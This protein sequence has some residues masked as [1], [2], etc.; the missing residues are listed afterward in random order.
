MT[1]NPTKPDLKTIQQ[2]TPDVNK[3]FSFKWLIILLAL[4]GACILA[5]YFMNFSGSW[6]NQADFGA[7]GDYVGGVLNPVL[8]FATV[9]LLIWSLKMQRD[10]LSL[11]RQE[12][13]LTRQELAETK[14]ETALS[15]QAMEAQVNHVKV[16]AELNELTRLLDR[17][18][19]KYETLIGMRFPLTSFR[20]SPSSQTM[21]DDTY[22]SL[23][24][25]KIK[26]MSANTANSLVNASTKN[27]DIVL[28]LNLIRREAILFAD[29]ALKYYSI[30]N[31]A[32]FARAYL[33]DALD[34]LNL[35]NRIYPDDITKNRVEGI[36]YVLV[37][38]SNILAEMPQSKSTQ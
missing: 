3:D 5:L 32:E 37:N 18:Q 29:L 28:H 34:I 33:F 4:L 30:N 31:S 17:S 14:E 38:I 22:K 11:S 8:G 7:F 23:L 27:S 2:T 16:E 25:R 35:V 19:T 12:L 21:L 24:E 9:G 1:T 20:T 15:R 10:E 36:N 6:G 26:N 13:A